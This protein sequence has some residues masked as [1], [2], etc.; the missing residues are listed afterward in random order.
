MAERLNKR[1]IDTRACQCHAFV[2]T[3]PSPLYRMIEQRLDGTLAEYVAARLQERVSWLSMA[4]EITEKTQI[5]VS[6][7]T[8]R[9]WFADRVTVTVTIAPASVG[10]TA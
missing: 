5:E 9:R 4:A 1:G 7:E 6:D 3:K 8:L 2:V 10:A